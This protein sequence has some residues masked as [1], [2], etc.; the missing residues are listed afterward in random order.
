MGK[1]LIPALPRLPRR[2][3]R[4]RDHQSDRRI[5]HSARR[6]FPALTDC[7]PA[8]KL[9]APEVRADPGEP[10]W[11][12]WGRPKQAYKG[13]WELAAG[14]LAD[15]RHRISGHARAAVTIQSGLTT[16]ASRRLT[17]HPLGCGTVSA[18][19]GA[20]AAVAA[21]RT[22]TTPDRVTYRN[23]PQV[24]ARRAGGGMTGDEQDEAV[25]A[26]RV[27]LGRGQ[28]DR[29]RVRRLLARRRD[30]GRRDHD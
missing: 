1:H 25:E 19:L 24:I 9:R 3:A 7:F 15:L 14:D 6:R 5:P 23:R 11:L 26:L 17:G 13:D 10:L 20:P 16:V 12:R 21:E 22:Q 30:R 29:R 18:A 2:T 4:R 28:R 27:R 8:R